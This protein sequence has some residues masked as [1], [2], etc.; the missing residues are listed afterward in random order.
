MLLVVNGDEEFAVDMDLDSL[1]KTVVEFG[2]T[3]RVRSLELRILASEDRL[4]GRDAVGF[5]EIELQR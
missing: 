3:L 1:R 5:S 4:V 2:A